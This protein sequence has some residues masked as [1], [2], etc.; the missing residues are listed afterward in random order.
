MEY[1]MKRDLKLI[2]LVPI[3]SL[4]LIFILYIF[5]VLEF[6]IS[7][8]EYVL[9]E[10]LINYQGG[11]VRRGLLGNIIFKLNLDFPPALFLKL[12]CISFILILEFVL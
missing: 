9:I 12:I 11:F 8:G 10:N 7:L 4:F 1:L 5:S 3:T 2:N 6:K